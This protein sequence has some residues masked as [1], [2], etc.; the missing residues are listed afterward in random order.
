MEDEFIEKEMDFIETEIRRLEKRLQTL[1]M[2][3]QTKDLAILRR[4][5][6]AT[7]ANIIRSCFP[8]AAKSLRRLMGLSKRFLGTNLSANL[9]A[10]R[11]LVAAC[12]LDFDGADGA[13]IE[14]FLED[15]AS[16]CDAER[17][18]ALIHHPCVT[19]ESIARAQTSVRLQGFSHLDMRLMLLTAKQAHER[20]LWTLRRTWILACVRQ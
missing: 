3:Q 5:A 8:Q 2:E 11:P 7:D 14:R 17:L 20:W 15:A 4:I 6:H 10:K 13:W 1:G 12:L 9:Q 19:R 18:L 16:N